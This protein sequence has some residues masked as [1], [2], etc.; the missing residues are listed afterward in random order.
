MGGADE[1]RR[2]EHESR[3]GDGSSLR[4]AGRSLV[5][6]KAAN[7]AFLIVQHANYAT[8]VKYFLLIK[9][10]V[11]AEELEGQALALLQD[12]ILVAEGKNQIYGTQLRRNEVTGQLELL[13]I[14]DEAN[15][16]QRRAEL[17]MPPLAEHLKLVRGEG[18]G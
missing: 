1:N 17:G 9:A 7:A 4:L 3:R 15:V 16:V 13:P 12:R 14:E 8:Q 6:D 11:E 2:A 5:G 18:G 10:A